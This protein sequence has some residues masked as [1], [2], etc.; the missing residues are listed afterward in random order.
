[1]SEIQTER[2]FLVELTELT[3]A[4]TQQIEASRSSLD[5]RPEAIAGRRRRVLRDGD[6]RFFAYTYFPHHIFGESSRFQEHFCTRFP[7]LLRLDGG[8]KEWWVAPRGEAKSS[9]LTKIGPVWCAVQALLQRAEVRKEISWEGDAPYFIDYVTLLGSELKLPTKLI[10]VQKTELTVNA[11]LAVDFPEACG[12]GSVWKVG[13]YVTNSGI[14]VEPF[15]ADQAIRGTFFGASRPKLLLGDDLITDKEAKSA[16]ERENRWTWLEKAIDYLGP[17]DGS[18]KFCGV[19]TILNKDDPISRAKRTIGHVVHHFKAIEQ[20]PHHMDL[21]EHCEALMRNEDERAVRAAADRGEV[22]GQDTLPSYLFYLAHQEQME[23]GAI[24]SWPAVRSLY[25]LMRQR[26]KN[27][28]AFGTEM[29]GEARSDED[30]VFSRWQFWVSRLPFWVWFGAVDPSMGKG[31]TSDPSAIVIGGF[32][33]ET[34]KLHVEYASSK[35]R[36]PSKLYADI[37]DL[38]REYKV[39][40]WAFENNNAYEAMRLELIKEGMNH[41]VPLSV[42]G[43]TAS[44]P[45]EVRIDSLEPVICDAFVPRILFNARLTALLSQLEE[46]PEKSTEHHYDLL[47]A[48]HLLWVISVTGSAPFSFGSTG[49][50]RAGS[51]LQDYLG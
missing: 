5:T 11:A 13:E 42:Q 35:R 10:E 1:M 49:E 43:V 39:S 19:G 21:W 7:Q 34:K 2:E 50:V 48:M 29:Q 46:W 18:V 26:A 3:A 41:H 47:V 37:I 36:V 24:T 40:R 45:A 14:K 12:R 23:Q 31:L 17:P 20:L 33:R 38:Q 51:R 32:D 27:S 9:L 28:K 6:F 16:T 22:A 30:Q 8:A 25:W 15:G 44:V 4:L